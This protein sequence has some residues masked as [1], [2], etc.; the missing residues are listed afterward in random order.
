M[1]WCIFAQNILAFNVLSLVSPVTYSIASLLKR[2]FVI[3]LAIL[4]FHQTVSALQ[5]FGIALTFYGLWMYNDSKT[6][7]DVLKAENKVQRKQQDREESAILP[8]TIA[9]SSGAGWS[10][11][12]HSRP[13]PNSAPAAASFATAELSG[14]R[15]YQMTS[16]KG[17][18]ND[19]PPLKSYIKDPTQSL[20]SPPDSDKEV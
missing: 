16:S 2:V 14:Y 9:S 11:A 12:S 7:D 3:V 6:K 20:P 17:G 1:D 19:V 5:W 13:L 4:W 18:W 8:L 15:S 10:G